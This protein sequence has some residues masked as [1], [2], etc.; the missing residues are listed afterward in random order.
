MKKGNRYVVFIGILMLIII[1]S[2]NGWKLVSKKVLSSKK[3]KKLII[4]RANDSISLDPA[5]TTEIESF[6]VTVNLY[7]NL[8]KYEKKGGKIIPSLAE[9]W[10]TSEDGLTWVF[11]LRKNVKFHDGTDFDAH[12]VQFNFERWMNSDNPYHTGYFSYWS[13]NFGGFPGIVKS[14]TAV[15]KYSLEIVLN[16]PYA[17]F[18]STLTMPVFGIASPDA[19]MKYNENFRQHPIGTG[20]FEF[21]SW[22][23]GKEIVLTKNNNYWGN[24]P[25]IDEV[26][27]RVIESNEERLK[28]LEEGKIHIADNLTAKDVE[29][30]EKNQNIDVYLRP[31]FNIGY[32]AM[33][34]QKEPF[35]NK[36]VRMAIGHLI[37]KDRMVKEVFNDLAR[38][39]NSFVPPMLWGYHENIK[40]L[41]YNPKKA[42]KLL[43]HAGYSKGFN[44]TLWVM[45]TP[46]AYFPNPML[47]A[48]F[49]KESLA[50]ADIRVEIIKYSWDEYIEKIKEGEHT[51][52]L[53]GWTGDHIDPDNFLYT[54]FASDNRRTELTSN[55]SFYNNK[56][57]DILLKQARQATDKEFRKNLYRKLQEIVN[58]NTPAIPL[59]HT[60][61][62]IGVSNKVKGYVPHLTGKETLEDVDLIS[63]R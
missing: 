57:V 45:D 62:I 49:I 22:R 52:I 8:V 2:M 11:K 47:L 34:N 7:D 32:L 1:T 36:E 33:N 6:K 63:K 59:V 15:S 5:I 55:Y 24:D 61:P 28:L 21:K 13:Y 12:A 29:R 51:L 39:A 3:N 56:E 19:I 48:E 58:E 18:L 16:E 14:V 43:I 37:D 35:D 10:K 44:T 46:R 26:V 50:K 41:E 60:M 27:F 54:F 30:I 38:P 23:A 9:S 17:P 4:A 31:F 40:S 53:T 20:P 25:K 42:K